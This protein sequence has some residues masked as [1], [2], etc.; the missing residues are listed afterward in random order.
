MLLDLKADYEED[1]L[2]RQSFI[3]AAAPRLET[4]RTGKPDKTWRPVRTDQAIY[5]R[6]TNLGIS[7]RRSRVECNLKEKE[8]RKSIIRVD[9]QDITIDEHIYNLLGLVCLDLRIATHQTINYLT[10]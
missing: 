6:R 2:T 7:H 8:I 1:R 4:W 5:K 10:S 9:D 3:D